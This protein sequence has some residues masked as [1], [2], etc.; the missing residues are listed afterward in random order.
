MKNIWSPSWN[1]LYG[2][3]TEDVLLPI[4]NKYK[5]GGTLKTK[6]AAIEVI[7]HNRDKFI[8]CAELLMPGQKENWLKQFDEMVFGDIDDKSSVEYLRPLKAPDTAKKILGIHNCLRS[9]VFMFKKSDWWK[10]ND[11]WNINGAFQDI[12]DVVVSLDPMMDNTMTE[13]YRVRGIQQKPQ[14]QAQIDPSSMGTVMPSTPNRYVVS[15]QN[16]CPN[17]SEIVQMCPK[18]NIT[19]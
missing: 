1:R 16:L 5:I 12:Q 15:S 10:D 17:L 3:P 4:I 9:L 7:V 19:T 6:K 13:Y 11:G 2:Y 8:E 18:I 14:I